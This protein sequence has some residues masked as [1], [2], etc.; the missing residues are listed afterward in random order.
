MRTSSLRKPARCHGCTTTHL[1]T[2]A[3]LCH[4]CA[5]NLHRVVVEEHTTGCRCT[6]CDLWRAVVERFGSV[7]LMTSAMR[8][9]LA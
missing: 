2:D 4:R 6:G 5:T 1:D 7:G 9:V 8:E 3:P